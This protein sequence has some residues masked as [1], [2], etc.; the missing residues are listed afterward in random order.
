MSLATD[1]QA[2]ADLIEATPAGQRGDLLAIVGVKL[3]KTTTHRKVG[4]LLVRTALD[5]GVHDT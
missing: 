5:Y 3:L 2:I 4:A 1:A